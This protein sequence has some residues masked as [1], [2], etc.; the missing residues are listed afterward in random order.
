M[1]RGSQGQWPSAVPRS[2]S[3]NTTTST[4]RKV[5]Y[6]RGAILTVLGANDQFGPVK[7]HNRAAH[8][9]RSAIRAG[10]AQSAGE[11]RQKRAPDVCECAK[12]QSL[13]PPVFCCVQAP[14]VVELNR[15]TDAS[16]VFRKQR[17]VL[18]EKRRG[19]AGFRRERAGPWREP[20]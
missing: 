18:H 6:C 12:A 3:E 11:A 16:E 19:V 5:R 4:D 8:P 20:H 14:A 7:A 2:L 9:Y 13:A 15:N 10:Q 1:S 17:T